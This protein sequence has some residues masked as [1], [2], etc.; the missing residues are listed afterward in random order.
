MSGFKPTSGE[1][2]ASGGVVKRQLLGRPR[3]RLFTLLSLLWIVVS[4]PALFIVFAGIGRWNQATSWPEKLR[5][6]AFE[7]W[8]GLFLILL[9]LVFVTLATH[10]HFREAPRE[11][12]FLDDNPDHDPQN[13]Y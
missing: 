13:L 11:E 9:H 8:I 12:V 5:S 7:Q 10:F 3:T 4:L 1:S 6:V 2:Q